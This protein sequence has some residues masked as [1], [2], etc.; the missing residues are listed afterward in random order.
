MIWT[1]P[2]VIVSSSTST[3][4]ICRHWSCVYISPLSFVP[5]HAFM[6]PSGTDLTWW[7]GFF[8]RYSVQGLSSFVAMNWQLVASSRHKPSCG[9][10]PIRTP[11][12]LNT[13][14]NIRQA[15]G[16]LYAG[17]GRGGGDYYGKCCP[18]FWVFV[19]QRKRPRDISPVELEHPLCST[20]LQT[21]RSIE[22]CISSYIG[23]KN[24]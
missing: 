15:T 3:F 21:I 17:V 6:L 14:S 4:E 13:F 16:L 1:T 18:M 12:I 23:P 22:I 19:S 7:A 11:L 8:S 10:N 20:L 24:I 9:W 2:D 5:D